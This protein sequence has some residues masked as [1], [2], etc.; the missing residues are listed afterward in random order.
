[1]IFTT[2]CRC[3][4]LSLLLFTACAIVDSGGSGTE[5]TTGIVGAVVDDRGEP[6]AH[7]Q[8]QL[9][10]DTYDPVVNGT[11]LPSDTTDSLGRYAFMAVD[12]GEYAVQAV[13]LIKR[14]RLLA[15]G[16]HIADSIITAN[17]TLRTPGSIKVALPSEINRATG[18]VYIPGTTVFT[19]VDN[20]TDFVVLDSAPA[21]LIHEIAFSSAGQPASGTIRYNVNV[22]SDDTAF[23][24]NPLWKNAVT[25]GLNTSATG[26]GV[27]EN[28]VDF[29]VL[30]RLNGGNFDFSQ[31]QPDGADIR[32]T[33]EDGT[34]LSHEIE[35]WDAAGHRAVL[36]VRVDTVRGNN[37]TQSIMMFWNNPA[38]TDASAGTA[39][40]DTAKG[41]QGV[42]HLGDIAE[43]PVGDATVNRYHGTSPDTARPQVARGVIG[44]CRVFDG[45][46]GYITMPGTAGGKLNFPEDGNYTVSAW[47]KLDTLDGAPHLIVAK[48]YEQ[49]FLRF[50]YFP[51]DA[52]LW[53]FSEFSRADSWQACTTAAVSGEWVLLTGV[54]RGSGQVLYCN[55]IPVD[56]T[57]NIYPAVNVSGNTSNDLS[58]GKFLKAVNVPNSD[59][60]SYC[61]FKGSIDEVR[62]CN[63]AK[64]SGWV[65]LCYMN[66]RLDDR[67]VVF[68]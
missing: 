39:V 1:M 38:V 3:I 44:N 56:S 48:G 11:T 57:P 23:V 40:F 66:Q 42:W 47:T 45:F 30:I 15:G 17:D 59:E 67:L 26:A 16:I 22:S 35:Q 60:D 20:Q 64:S 51:S 34:V 14:T 55:G 19:L 29:P 10:P 49:Y 27:T 54:S 53:E 32:F 65:R 7:V 63:T 46:S 28:A 8:V 24:Y 36:W 68:R 33:G 5:T 13:H 21:G 52:P 50:T 37:S 41:F 2:V 43:G 18:Y 61:Y 62:I 25:I 31:A 4:L 58:I 6:Q 9:L 12:P